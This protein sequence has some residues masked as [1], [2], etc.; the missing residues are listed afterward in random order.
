MLDMVSVEQRLVTLR[1]DRPEPE[2]AVDEW[3]GI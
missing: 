3:Q 1:H 2:F